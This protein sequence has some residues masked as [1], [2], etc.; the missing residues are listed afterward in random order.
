[1]QALNNLIDDIGAK[2]HP[3]MRRYS[4]LLITWWQT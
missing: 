3:D 2:D 1:M 4:D